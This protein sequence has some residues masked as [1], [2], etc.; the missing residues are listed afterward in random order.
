MKKSI[1]L[2]LVLALAQGCASYKYAQKVKTVSFSSDLSKG[3]SVGNIRG[4]DCTWSVL[5]NKLGEDPTVDKAFINTRNQSTELEAMGLK[6]GQS[7]KS[8]RYVN[9]VSTESSGFNAGIIAK[10]CLVV[11]GIGY[12]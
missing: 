6:K 7:E 3:Q 5:G 4:E 11:K 8:L 1:L 9:N 2:I 12:K 10:N